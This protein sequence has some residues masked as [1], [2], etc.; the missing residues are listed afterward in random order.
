MAGPKEAELGGIGVTA[1][2]KCSCGS[3]QGMYSPTFSGERC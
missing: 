2:E 3:P 1:V